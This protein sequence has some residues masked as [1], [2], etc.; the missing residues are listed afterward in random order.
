MFITVYNQLMKRI[1]ICAAPLCPLVMPVLS[2][3]EKIRKYTQQ[4]Y[5]CYYYTIYSLHVLP[6][7]AW[8][9]SENCSFLPPSKDE[10]LLPVN[11]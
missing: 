7:P 4:I 3:F 10:Q 8:V 1:N 6:V 5:C 9:S 2:Y 11:W